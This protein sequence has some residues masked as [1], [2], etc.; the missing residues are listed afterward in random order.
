MYHIWVLGISISGPFRA[1]HRNGF[2]AR[3]SKMKR[4]PNSPLFLKNI[5][6]LFKY[7]LLI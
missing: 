6:H 7:L 1:I 4:A 5:A 3:P 2:Q